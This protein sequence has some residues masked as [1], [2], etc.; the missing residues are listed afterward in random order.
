MRSR[1]HG[2]STPI[3]LAG[4]VIVA[5]VIG[6]AVAL[7]LGSDD[8]G[9]ASATATATTAAATPTTPA[10]SATATAEP[11]TP[12]PPTATAAPVTEVWSIEFQ[13]SGGFAGLA[14]SLSISSDGQA[15]YEDMGNQLTETGTLSATDLA[16]LRALIDSSGFFSQAPKQDAPC[17][18]CFNLRISVTLNGQSHTVEA[19]DIGVDPALKPLVDK[20]TLLLQDGLGQ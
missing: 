10:P 2:I 17:A 8:S 9:P 4:A 6:A 20:L 5:I 7:A 15:R 1:I 13:R 12:V 3:L 14:Q 18:D 11:A 16:E 19:V